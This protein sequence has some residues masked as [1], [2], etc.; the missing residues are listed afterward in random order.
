MDSASPR[1]ENK[2]YLSCHH[3]EM[4]EKNHWK[5]KQVQ[6]SSSHLDLANEHQHPIDPMESLDFLGVCRG[7]PK[8]RGWFPQKGAFPAVFPWLFQEL[9]LLKLS[10]HTR[11]HT[12]HGKRPTFFSSNRQAVKLAISSFLLGETQGLRHLV[13]QLPNQYLAGRPDWFHQRVDPPFERGEKGSGSFGS[14]DLQSP[15]ALDLR[16]I[17][18]GRTHP[19]GFCWT[20][21]P[22]PT[23][24][25]LNSNWPL[26]PRHP[27][28][29]SSSGWWFDMK[30]RNHSDH[31]WPGNTW[32]AKPRRPRCRPKVWPDGLLRC[33]K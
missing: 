20:A 6:I 33:Q 32:Q 11:K 21:D 15:L 14:L 26:T 28:D 24:P 8:I 1:G 16:Q 3:L 23:R 25:K 2:K 30:G 19:L 22:T 27:R 4:V 17:L 9:H 5:K 7:I 31:P 29:V 18:R 13:Y 12:K 10:V